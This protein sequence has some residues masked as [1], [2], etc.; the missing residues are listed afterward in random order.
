MLY[1]YLHSIA[2]YRY[3]QYFVRL[4]RRNGKNYKLSA[5]H[6]GNNLFYGYLLR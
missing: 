3:I 2:D 4:F 1:Y 6:F 5:F